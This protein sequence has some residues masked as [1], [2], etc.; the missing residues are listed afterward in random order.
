MRAHCEAINKTSVHTVFDPLRISPAVGVA[1]VVTTMTWYPCDLAAALVVQPQDNAVQSDDIGHWL[2]LVSIFYATI[3]ILAAFGGFIGYSRFRDLLERAKEATESAE[4]YLKKV[5]TIWAKIEDGNEANREIRALEPESA[6]DDPERATAVVKTV[7]DSPLSS[8]VDRQRAHALR[9]QR[10]DRKNDAVV[11]WRAIAKE[12]EKSGTRPNKPAA[13]A[14]C[15]VGYL[16]DRPER[17]LA[18][19]ERA[20][21]LDSQCALAYTRRGNVKRRLGRYDEA[22]DDQSEAIKIDPYYH[23][24]LLNRGVARKKRAKKKEKGWEDDIKAAIEDF[25]KATLWKQDYCKAY[26]QLGAAYAVQD[27]YDKAI[28]YSSKAIACDRGLCGRLLRSG[29]DICEARQT[30]NGAER[31]RTSVTIGG[32][33]SKTRPSYKNQAIVGGGRRLVPK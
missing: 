26:R 23:I 27:E 2:T 13:E 14:W 15:S 1:A 30:R 21:A 7:L 5:E 32:A 31:P 9:L 28:D 6:K 19:Y 3:G 22:I 20:I 11:E 8:V 18:A 10:Q 12:L 16:E 29:E 17:Q 24:A 33:K 25:K 4:Q